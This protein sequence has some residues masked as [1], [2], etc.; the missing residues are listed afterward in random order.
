MD[1]ELLRGCEGQQHT[2]RYHVGT[3]AQL[4]PNRYA[5]S[6]WVLWRPSDAC[7]ELKVQTPLNLNS[8]RPVPHTR[9]PLASQNEPAEV[10]TRD[11]AARRE[12]L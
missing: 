12:V 5:H 4:D 1:L 8:S 6:A 7:F 9:P 3:R 10:A 11:R 2:S